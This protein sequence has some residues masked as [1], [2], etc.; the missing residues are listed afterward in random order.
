M[1]IIA[2]ASYYLSE[3]L[4]VANFGNYAVWDPTLRRGQV[5]ERLPLRLA[6]ICAAGLV[7][8]SQASASFVRRQE[9][10]TTAHALPPKAR[11]GTE[12][13]AYLSGR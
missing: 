5:S 4:L 10:L 11:V 1:S 3:S 9:A 12:V 13:V 8:M 6:A 2:K 7:M